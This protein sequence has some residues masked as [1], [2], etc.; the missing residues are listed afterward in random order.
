MCSIVIILIITVVIDHNT[1]LE[2]LQSD[3]SHCIVMYFW[4]SLQCD[5]AIN[6][7]CSLCVCDTD[8]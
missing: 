8:K 1:T 6:F 7:I 4:L 5:N 2:S 3:E